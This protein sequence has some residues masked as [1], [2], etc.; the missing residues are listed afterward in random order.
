[1]LSISETEEVA[2]ANRVDEVK[3]ASPS[4]YPSELL[5]ELDCTSSAAAKARYSMDLR[6]EKGRKGR[7]R[8]G[9]NFITGNYISRFSPLF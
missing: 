6:L 2:L 5:L 8:R 9:V 1:L 3:D 7:E 4:G